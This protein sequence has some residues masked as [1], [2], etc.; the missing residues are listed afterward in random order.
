[1]K[2]RPSP[3]PPWL[4]IPWFAREATVT[5]ADD[6]FLLYQ[7]QKN[8][9][10]CLLGLVDRSFRLVSVSEWDTRDNTNIF[11][12]SRVAV[13]NGAEWWALSVSLYAWDPLP[14]RP[15]DVFTL[16]WELWL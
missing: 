1:M 16:T 5:I 3:G 12:S 4:P 6:G 13:P 8:D 14:A 7:A 2:H 10:V 9:F 15:W 11:G